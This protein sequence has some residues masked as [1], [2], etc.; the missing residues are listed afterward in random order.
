MIPQVS[1]ECVIKGLF[2]LLVHSLVMWHHSV[3]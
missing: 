3:V 2:F 1:S